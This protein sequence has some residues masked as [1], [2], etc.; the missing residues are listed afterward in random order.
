MV[1][2]AY[3]SSGNL[4]TTISGIVDPTIISQPARVIAAPGE[5]ATF[6]VVVSNSAEVTFQWK[7][8]NI[9]IAGATGDSLLLTNINK[10]DNEGQYSVVV[11][12]SAGSVTSTPA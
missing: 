2:Y 3:D 6:S 8:N 7:F 12:N 9:D 5:I 11:T 4:L 1:K 10:V